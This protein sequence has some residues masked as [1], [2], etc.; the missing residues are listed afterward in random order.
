MCERGTG[1]DVNSNVLISHSTGDAQLDKAVW[2]WLSWDKVKWLEKMP[3]PLSRGNC[4]W[5]CPHAHEQG[6]HWCKARGLALPA[7]H[8]ERASK[9][10]LDQPS[11][12]E[13]PVNAC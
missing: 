10:S 5:I 1:G 3:L 12:R 11:E 8:R 7:G 6:A 9:V 13:Q 2:Q 4:L